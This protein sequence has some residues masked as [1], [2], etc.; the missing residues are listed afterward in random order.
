MCCQQGEKS[1]GCKDANHTDVAR[2]W[3]IITVMLISKINGKFRIFKYFFKDIGSLLWNVD[4][5]A[6]IKLYL[7]F[8][9]FLRRFLFLLQF[10][11][12]KENYFFGKLILQ[13]ILSKSSI[14]PLTIS[15]TRISALVARTLQSNM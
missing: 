7:Q 1:L 4:M 6:R 14:V 13:P 11:V 8:Q 3:V 2:K 12:Q 9:S 10:L 5:D 15:K